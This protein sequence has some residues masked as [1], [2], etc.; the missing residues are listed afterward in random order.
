M[1]NLSSSGSRLPLISEEE[2]ETEEKAA[3]Y[4]I[5]QLIAS[6]QALISIH[7]YGLESACQATGSISCFPGT[8][9]KTKGILCASRASWSLFRRSP[10]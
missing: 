5:D 1:I 7:V 4:L 6:L 9:L 2:N 10:W 8:T 3:K